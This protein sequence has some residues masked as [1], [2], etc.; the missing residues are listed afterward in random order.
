MEKKRVVLSNTAKSKLTDL[1][2]YL[3]NTW[4]KKVQNE[5]IAK[6][7]RSLSRISYYPNSCPESTEIQGLFKCVVTKQ[8]SLFYRVNPQEIEV[9]T[10]FDT[11][12][13]TKKLKMLK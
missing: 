3:E 9:V 12:Q 11:R 13:D 4:S 7:D 8:T 6:M 2:D 1:L 10:L 5:F